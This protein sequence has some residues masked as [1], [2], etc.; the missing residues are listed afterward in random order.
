[1]CPCHKINT[2]NNSSKLSNTLI[3][4]LIV[5]KRNCCLS[6]QAKLDFPYFEHIEM[7]FNYK[8]SN[9]SAGIGLAQLAVLED[10]VEKRRNIY[11]YYKRNLEMLPGIEFLEEPE[12]YFSNRWLTTIV[13][14][15]DIAGFKACE[16]REFLLE[17]GIESRFLWKP[18]HLQPMHKG[19]PYSGGNIAENL[20]SNGICLPSGSGL[21]KEE[22]DRIINSVFILHKEVILNAEKTV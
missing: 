22:L 15:P 4:R 18:M 1:L 19:A 3:Y 2:K 16:L 14:A 7:G 9:M 12:G 10:R 21:N 20:F 17:D 6:T 8:M 5:F 11:A 13:I